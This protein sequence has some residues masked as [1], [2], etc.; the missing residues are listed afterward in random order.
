MRMHIVVD[1]DLIAELDK[2]IG[3]RKRSAFITSLLRRA[4]EDRRRWDAIES[5]LGALR[6]TGHEWDNDP[7]EWVRA[8]R[9]ADER[10]VG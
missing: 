7:A 6:D 8:Q 5:A 10:R 2:R 4:L 3:R 1:D 9:D